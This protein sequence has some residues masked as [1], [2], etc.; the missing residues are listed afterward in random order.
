MQC[1]IFISGAPSTEEKNMF[2]QRRQFAIK[3]RNIQPTLEIS[4][5][6]IVLPI[7]RTVNCDRHRSQR[8][9]TY[10][11]TPKMV[12]GFPEVYHPSSL[13]S[14]YSS[15]YLLRFLV[16]FQV[17]GRSML[18]QSELL[19]VRRSLQSH[20]PMMTSSLIL[21]YHLLCYGHLSQMCN[22]VLS[23]VLHVLAVAK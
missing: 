6:L 13:R 8:L 15:C 1:L 5:M 7:V 9:M 16:L 23:L 10:K 4:F 12:T 19:I 17:Y 11:L 2:H 21:C 18:L 22:R 14:G 20:N 3:R